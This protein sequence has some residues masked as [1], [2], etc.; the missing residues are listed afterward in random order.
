MINN[1]NNIQIN[2]VN[3]LEEDNEGNKIH[4]HLYDNLNKD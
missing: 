2:E 3:G 4:E 1:N